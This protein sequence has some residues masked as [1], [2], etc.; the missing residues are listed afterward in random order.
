MIQVI[1]SDGSGTVNGRSTDDQQIV[2]KGNPPGPLTTYVEVI[3]IADSNQS[4]RAEIWSNFGDT[5]G[6]TIL[7]LASLFA[8]H[9]P[10]LM[11]YSHEP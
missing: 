10:A 5:L 6:I 2:V 7:L 8:F 11:L 4:I 3:G 9:F 1:R